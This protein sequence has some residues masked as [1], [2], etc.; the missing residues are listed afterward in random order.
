MKAVF[1]LLLFF[2]YPTAV[3]AASFDV[4]PGT[5]IQDVVNAA[6][7]GDEIHINNGTYTDPVNIDKPLTLACLSNTD[8]IINTGSSNIGI[9]LIG[10]ADNVTIK[11]CKIT[12]NGDGINADSVSNLTLQNLIVDNNSFAISGVYA[13]NVTGLNISGTTFSNNIVGLDLVG[14]TSGVTV[15]TSVFTNNSTYHISNDTTNSVTATNGNSWGSFN[16]NTINNKLY[17]KRDLDSLGLIIFDATSP[18][19]DAGVDKVANTGFIQDATASDT[20]GIASY[21]WSGPS[22]VI[23]NDP[24]IED[25]NISA[26]TDGTYTVTLTVTDNSGNTNSDTFQLIWDATPPTITGNISPT[27][28]VSGW[29]NVSTGAPTI[30][31]SCSP[32]VTCPS[33]Y[34]F[35]NGVSQSHSETVTDTAGNSATSEI[36]G[37]NVDLSSPS[38]SFNLPTD[39]SLLKSTVLLQASGSDTGGSSLNPLMFSYKK[40]ADSEFTDIGIDSE[41]PYQLSWDTTTV[42]DGDYV[43]RVAASDGAG[44]ISWSD[45]NVTVDNTKPVSSASSPTYD[46]SGTIPVDFTSAD[47][48]SGVASVALWY[49]FN[50]GAWT[51]SGLSSDFDPANIDGTYE[52][53]SIATD[54]AGNVELAPEAA[55]SSTIFDHSNP[56]ASWDSPAADSSISGTVTLQVSASDSPAGIASI[57]FQYKR[58]DGIDSFH[59]TPALWD[60]TSLPLDNYTIRAIVTDN[61]G[62]ATTIDRIVGIAAVITG[63]SS[64][65]ISTNSFTVTWTTDRPTSGRIVYDTVSHPVLGAAPNYSYAFST[66]T[67]DTSPETTSHTITV[68]GLSDNTIYY[69]RMVSAGSPTVVSDEYQNKTFSV[70]GAGTSTSTSTS[71]STPLALVLG[72]AVQP[73][74]FAAATPVEEVLGLSTEPSPIPTATLLPSPT[75]EVQGAST[76]N[77]NWW[78]VFIPFALLGLVISGL[79]FRRRS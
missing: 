70:S 64:S 67:I 52:F 3:S 66:G 74:Y 23:F 31:Y 62:N 19:V 36:S 56:T 53:Y 7:S 68:S 14:T 69:W 9:S 58:N 27:I 61:A 72:A 55:D 16:F 38:I 51:Y 47:N 71:T 32:D 40:S 79:L 48:L 42:T 10:G 50:G 17:D 26:S 54:A 6:S 11:N 39:G 12:G 45:I 34:L 4:N 13:N 22:E 24:T 29:Y 43:L 59:D 46:N 41:A 60:T 57:L 33:S 49:R 63:E 78:W 21:L 15:S 37:I 20:Y 2:V 44:N 8:T 75:P 76:S 73:Q 35:G 1:I 18:T 5:S 30:T 77:F 25:P 65:T 28:P